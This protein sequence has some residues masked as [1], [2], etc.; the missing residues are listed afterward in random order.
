MTTQTNR[1]NWTD[2][3]CFYVDAVDGQR[4]V[5]LAGPFPDKAQAVAAVDAARTLA[6][7]FG[8]P[9]AWFYA[10]GTCLL[11]NGHKEGRFN[12]EIGL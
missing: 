12:K 7:D 11:K 9:K 5:L 1:G 10:Y 2:A 3:P 4:F 8:D 6:L